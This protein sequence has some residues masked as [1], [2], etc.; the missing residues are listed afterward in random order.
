M[1]LETLAMV[2]L[3]LIIFFD[4]RSTFSHCFFLVQKA[5]GNAV[6]KRDITVVPPLSS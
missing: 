1:P 3:I 6:E 4:D 5:R 2:N